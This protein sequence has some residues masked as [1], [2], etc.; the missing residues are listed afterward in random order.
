MSWWNAADD[1]ETEEEEEEVLFRD[2]D[3][4]A[5]VGHDLYCE[6]LNK[7]SN[8]VQKDEIRKNHE[9]SGKKFTDPQFPANSTS[10]AKD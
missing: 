7:T 4:L 10:L 9:S 2:K 1:S 3:D 5:K 8:K 6:V